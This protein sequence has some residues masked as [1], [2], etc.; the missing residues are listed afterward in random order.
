MFIA[1]LV[2]AGRLY[3]RPVPRYREGH[4]EEQAAPEHAAAG[5]S[6]RSWGQGAAGRERRALLRRREWDDNEVHHRRAHNSKVET[7]RRQ[8]GERWQ[9][10]TRQEAIDHEQRAGYLRKLTTSNAQLSPD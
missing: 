8:G 2:Y 6:Q 10:V 9:A 5:A 3:Q 4:G 1:L 7:H